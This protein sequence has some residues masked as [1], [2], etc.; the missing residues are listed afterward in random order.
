M[1]W[2]LLGKVKM[3]GTATNFQFIIC[4]SFQRRSTSFWV[5]SL[6]EDPVTYC[7]LVEIGWS[8]LTSLFKLYC[9]FLLQKKKKLH[10]RKVYFCLYILSIVALRKKIRISK[11]LYQWGYK[12]IGYWYWNNCNCCNYVTE[13]KLIDYIFQQKNIFY[14]ILIKS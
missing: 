3:S 8:L 9:P 7:S 1:T 10:W 2:F 11:N 4:T 13:S 6:R 5:I 12:E 14:A